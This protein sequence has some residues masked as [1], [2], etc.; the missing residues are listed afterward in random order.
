MGLCALLGPPAAGA[1]G[2][3]EGR[4]PVAEAPP[5]PALDQRY[6]QKVTGPIAAP[7]PPVSVVWVEGGPASPR[8]EAARA[9]VR[10]VQFQFNPGLLVV[11][12]GT[13]VAFPNGDDTYHSIFSIPT[14]PGS[15]GTFRCMRRT[16]ASISTP[17]C[18]WRR[19]TRVVRRTLPLSL[20]AASRAASR[21]EVARRTNLRRV[22]A[23]V[24]GRHDASRLHP[25]GAAPAPRSLGA[26]PADQFAHRPRRARLSE[27][28]RANGP[29]GD[30]RV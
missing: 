8:R 22:A 30:D 6:L 25:D 5:P 13:A 12:V 17:P 10:Q 14:G 19:A 1:A 29:A 7:D 3:I 28:R 27:V 16:V 21:E 24:G 11:P 23:S 9:E 20:W 2:I 26:A 18:M 15:I 4:V